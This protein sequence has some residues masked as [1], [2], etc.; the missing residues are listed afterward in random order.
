MMHHKNSIALVIALGTITGAVALGTPSQVAAASDHVLLAQAAPMQEAPP[1][2]TA[3]TQSV[4]KTSHTRMSP[5]QRVEARIKDLQKGF[6]IT[7]A[8]EPLWT[9]VTQV[10]R[11]NAKAIETIVAGRTQKIKT[12]SAIDDLRSYESLAEAHADGLKKLV[13]AFAPLYDSM[14]DS[15]KKDADALFRHDERHPSTGTKS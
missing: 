3:P 9:N 5:S 10:M 7:A 2:S 6:H 13:A 15:Q 14:S 11:D 1:S 4:P 12:M 8:Q